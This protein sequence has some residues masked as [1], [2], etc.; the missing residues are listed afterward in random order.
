MLVDAA[1]CGLGDNMLVDADD[2]AFC[3]ANEDVSIDA[4]SCA[5]DDDKPAD[6]AICAPEHDVVCT[7]GVGIEGCGSVASV[8]LSI[9]G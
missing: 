5:P 2:A 7:A 8:V 4:A 6:D 1:S 9:G 3:V